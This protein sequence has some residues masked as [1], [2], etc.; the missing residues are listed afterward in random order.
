MG[1]PDTQG[2]V[3]SRHATPRSPRPRRCQ[4]A[5][6][7]RVKG[8]PR[9]VSAPFL[10]CVWPSKAGRLAAAN[11]ALR[12]VRSQIPGCPAHPPSCLLRSLVGMRRQLR[13]TLLQLL[14]QA[15]GPYILAR[16]NHQADEQK[17]Y[18]LQDWQKEA[19][20]SEEDE[21]PAGQQYQPPLALLIQLVLSEVWR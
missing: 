13:K 16:Q 3:T 14:E 17:Q 21:S 7:M 4:M 6:R 11:A 5:K 1:E 12:G 18:A 19:S 15:V 8:G 10:A 2:F 9:S 20:D